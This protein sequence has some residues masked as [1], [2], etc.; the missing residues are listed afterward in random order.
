MNFKRTT[1]SVVCVFLK[2]RK[3]CFVIFFNSFFVV[4]NFMDM[5]AVLA[6]VGAGGAAVADDPE[7]VFVGL[8]SLRFV[9]VGSAAVVGGLGSAAFETPSPE[10]SAAILARIVA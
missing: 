8:A 5:G 9:A 7:V 2:R 6:I 1:S 3:R 4:A 10:A